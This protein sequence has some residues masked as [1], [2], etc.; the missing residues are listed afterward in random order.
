MI[1]PSEFR[2]QDIINHWHIAALALTP[3]LK[4]KKI[5]E[6]GSGMGSFASELTKNG[7]RNIFCTDGSENYVKILKK[8]GFMAKQC[9]FNEKLPFNSKSFD[10]VISLEVIEHLEKSEYFLKEINRILKKEGVLILSTPNFAWFPYRLHYLFGK[11][12]YLEGCHIRHFTFIS[13][14]E[15]LK[16]TG[17]KLIA[18]NSLSPI[19]IVNRIL[20]RL[21]RRPVWLK[22]SKTQN[23]FAQD[24]VIKA[25]K[26]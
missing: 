21:K 7:Y 1:D 8:K 16:K 17:F 26:S 22:I 9:D 6:L 15:K 2:K 11:P 25:I 18:T 4:G 10:A 5:L 14:T 13:L 24:L 3:N 20:L 19:L 12:P 23:V